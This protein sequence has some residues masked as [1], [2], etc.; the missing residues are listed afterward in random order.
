MDSWKI[1]H[2]DDQSMELDSAFIILSSINFVKTLRLVIFL[3]ER[4]LR[5]KIQC[6]IVI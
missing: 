3:Q 5:S 2:I 6:F 1:N 4:V